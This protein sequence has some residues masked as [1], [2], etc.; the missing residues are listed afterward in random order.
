MCTSGWFHGSRT[1]HRF[2]LDVWHNSPQQVRKKADK[3]IKREIFREY[4]LY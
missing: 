1:L 2:V 3:E 4:F